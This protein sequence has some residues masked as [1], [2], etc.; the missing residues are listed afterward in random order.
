MFIAAFEPQDPVVHF[1]SPGRDRPVLSAKMQGGA[2]VFDAKV[3]I[4]CQAQAGLE[5]NSREYLLEKPH[6]RA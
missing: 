3:K 1:L 6:G 2:F 5:R 4:G